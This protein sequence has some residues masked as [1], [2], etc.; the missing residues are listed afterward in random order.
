MHKE[1]FV[2]FFYVRMNA[3]ERS[4]LRRQP[5]STVS[6]ADQ[7]CDGFSLFSSIFLFCFIQ[8]ACSQTTHSK[9]FDC[10]ELYVLDNVLYCVKF[11]RRLDDRK[12]VTFSRGN[13]RGPTSG[14]MGFSVC[15]SRRDLIYYVHICAFYTFET[16]FPF[17]WPPSVAWRRPATRVFPIHRRHKLFH[18]F[19]P[20]NSNYRMDKPTSD[21]VGLTLQ[22]RRVEK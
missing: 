6:S 21:M 5:R 11:P 20:T 3:D 13:V 9:D 2:F 16:P 12:L 19:E 17:F 18:P 10:H 4:F 8:I 22:R 1:L 7:C 15:G 14:I